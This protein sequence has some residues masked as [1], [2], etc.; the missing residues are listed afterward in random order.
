MPKVV[1]ETTRKDY[2]AEKTWEILALQGLGGATVRAIAQ[3]C[4][5]SIGSIQH[6]F[7]TQDELLC[8]AMELV[9]HRAE[10]RLNERGSHSNGPA[11]TLET[12]AQLLEELLPL[13]DQRLAEA[14]TWAAFQA[15]ALNH[16][17]LA[18]YAATMDALLRAFCLRVL[19]SLAEGRA[20]EPGRANPLE[21]ARLHSLLDG[22]TMGILSGPNRQRCQETQ[23]VLAAHLSSL[24]T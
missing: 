23:S 19:Q 1:D 21:A 8:Y 6:A 2:I 20:I 11:L 15:A 17:R 4:H 16:E 18:G 13:D 24:G 14:R 3:A 22:L 9:V 7:K 5:L 10:D 12:A